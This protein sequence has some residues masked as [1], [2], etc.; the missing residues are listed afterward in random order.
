[1]NLCAKVKEFPS[2]C[3]WD[4]GFTTIGQMD[5]RKTSCLRQQLSQAQSNKNTC[6][7]IKLR[8]PPDQQAQLF[9]ET[10]FIFVMSAHMSTHVCTKR[11]NSGLIQSQPCPFTGID[12]SQKQQPEAKR[13]HKEWC[14]VNKDDVWG[15]V[16]TCQSLSWSPEHP[17]SVWQQ[18]WTE[19]NKEKRTEI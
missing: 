2:V 6:A 14:V 19:L 5:N 7:L 11:C 16:L 17:L 18:I 15:S 4:I 1:M 13:Q 9:Q 8:E 3:S 10:S 12:Q